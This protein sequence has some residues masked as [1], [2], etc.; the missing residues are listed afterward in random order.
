M[1]GID[2]ARVRVRSR[3]AGNPPDTIDLRAGHA[4]SVG[5]VP[6]DARV[7]ASGKHLLAGDAGFVVRGVTYGSFVRRADGYAFPPPAQVDADFRQIAGFGLNTVRLYSVPPVDVRRAATEAGLRLIVGVHYRD[8]RYEPDP[9]R[10]TNRVVLDAGRRALD[11]AFESGGGNPT[12]L[13]YSVGNEVPA[14]I[15]RVHGPSAVAD[16]LGVLLEHARQGDP[17]ALRTYTNFPSTE[18]L[19]VPGQTLA[20]FNVFL[21]DRPAFRRYLRRLQVVTGSLPL[22]ITE[23]GLAAELRGIDAQAGSL[24]WQ[25]DEVDEVGCAGATIFSFTDEWGVADKDVEGWGFGITTVDRAPKPAAA[26]VGAWARRPSPAPR[27]GWP[28][29][30]VVVCAYNEERTIGACLASLAACDYPG[31]EV[32]VCDDGSTDGTLDIARRFPFAVLALPHAGLSAARNAGVAAASGEL[33]AF[34]DA[35]AACHRN[36]P[37]HLVRCFDVEHVVAAGGPNLPVE[38]A[39][40]VERAVAASPGAPCE[41]LVGDDRAEHVPGCNMAFRRSALLDVGGFDVVYTAAGDDVDVCWK[42]LDGGGEIAFSPATQVHHRRRGTV[43]GYLRQERGYG[44]AERLLMAAH[45]HRFTPTGHIRWRGSIYGG[46]RLLPPLLRPVV[47]HG[48]Q[49]QAPFQTVA[50]RPA[51]LALARLGAALPLALLVALGG[52]VGSV[53]ASAWLLLFPAAVALM[54][55]G[56]ASTVAATLVVHGDEPAPR[57]FRALVAALHLVQPLARSW[58]RFTGPRRPP[59]EPVRRPWW[60]HRG[61]WLEDL[62]RQFRRRSLRVRSGGPHDGWDLEVR[63]RTHAIRVTTAVAWNWEPQSSLRTVPTRSAAML[64]GAPVPAALFFG[65]ARPVIAAVV[66][67]GPVMLAAVAAVCTRRLVRHVVRSTTGTL[68]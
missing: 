40:L 53:V 28:P 18:Y 9:G 49:G 5:S 2:E 65:G 50:N 29:L 1:P 6:T 51:D 37:F 68:C 24:A 61:A 10:A 15:V 3:E 22:V 17:A 46:P 26:T 7:R 16:V 67:I 60:G 35:D 33:V 58:G 25:L 31:L 62:E 11:E 44:R 19:D 64:V 12:V 41:V 23:L 39:P 4:S 27:G 63:R 36:W 42:L 48:Y 14:D 56:Y 21:E 38:G 8:W 59:V 45:L 66:A 55:A 47:Y 54:V 32:I 34:L 20:T 30:S 13:A 52:S 57:R 43:A